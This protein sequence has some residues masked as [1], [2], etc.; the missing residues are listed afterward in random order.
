MPALL[1]S[2][3]TALLLVVTSPSQILFVSGLNIVDICF[4]IPQNSVKQQQRQKKKQQ[5][6]NITCYYEGI[7]PER[8]EKHQRLSVC[9]W[10]VT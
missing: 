7:S 5:Q 1:K 6:I 10:T 4:Q 2:L 9:A 8:K 3:V